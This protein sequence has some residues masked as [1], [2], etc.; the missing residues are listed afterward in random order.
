MFSFFPKGGQ[1][2]LLKLF[3]RFLPELILLV[4]LPD[5]LLLIL[6]N[7]NSFVE[8]SQ[9]IPIT[10]SARFNLLKQVHFLLINAS[11]THDCLSSD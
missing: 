1:I 3:L 7:R 5:L 4:V 10:L 6:Q 11:Y 9:F 8:M 2:S